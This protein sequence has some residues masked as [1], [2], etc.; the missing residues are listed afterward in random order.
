M[1]YSTRSQANDSSQRLDSPGIHADRV[2]QRTSFKAPKTEPALIETQ[3]NAPFLRLSQQEPNAVELLR[4][5]YALNGGKPSAELDSLIDEL[6]QKIPA[7]NGEGTAEIRANIIKVIENDESVTASS[8]KADVESKAEPKPKSR[9]PSVPIVKT[10]DSDGDTVSDDESVSSTESFY[11]A[12]GEEVPSTGEVPTHVFLTKDF[13]KQLNK[14]AAKSGVQKK[15]AQYKSDLESAKA[16]EPIQTKIAEATK[17]IEALVDMDSFNKALDAVKSRVDEIA[18]ATSTEKASVVSLVRQ[19]E[20]QNRREISVL[21]GNKPVAEGFATAGK[22]G[23]VKAATMWQA[24]TAFSSVVRENASGAFQKI[25][26]KINASQQKVAEPNKPEIELNMAKLNALAKRL[27]KVQEL[28]KEILSRLKAELDKAREGSDNKKTETLE[29]QVDK[30]RENT[31]EKKIKEHKDRITSLR[32]AVSAADTDVKLINNLAEK[33][34]VKTDSKS[35]AN[36]LPF[37]L[38][39]LANGAESPIVKSGFSLNNALEYLVVGKGNHAMSRS[40]ALRTCLNEFGSEFNIFDNRGNHSPVVLDGA[41]RSFL[42][43]LDGALGEPNS[44]RSEKI[45]Q[46]FGEVQIDGTKQ[47]GRVFIHKLAACNVSAAGFNPQTLQLD[48]PSL[49]FKVETGFG[50]TKKFIPGRAGVYARN[51]AEHLGNRLQVLGNISSNLQAEVFKNGAPVDLQASLITPQNAAEASSLIL[52]ALPNDLLTTN[53]EEVTTFMKLAREF[54][55][56]VD[57][58][59]Q[60]NEAFDSEK[61]DLFKVKFNEF[62]VKAASWVANRGEDGGAGKSVAAAHEISRDIANSRKGFF[63]SAPVA[64]GN[65][66]N[67]AGGRAI[68]ESVSAIRNYVSTVNQKERLRQQFV[69]PENSAIVSGLKRQLL[70]L[71]DP[72]NE[73]EANNARAL[74]TYLEGKSLSVKLEGQLSPNLKKSLLDVGN[75]L[76]RA[77]EPRSNGKPAPKVIG[78]TSIQ[79]NSIKNYASSNLAKFAADATVPVRAAASTA[80]STSAPAARPNT[81]QSSFKPS[82]VAPNLKPNAAANVKANDAKRS[83]ASNDEWI[84]NVWRNLLGSNPEG[85]MANIKGGYQRNFGFHYPEPKDDSSAEYE[86]TYSENSQTYFKNLDSLDEIVRHA[87]NKLDDIPSAVLK[88]MRDLL[89]VILEIEGGHAINAQ[90]TPLE[91]RKKD[92][93]DVSPNQFRCWLRSSWG[94]AVSTLSRDE[95]INKVDAASEVLRQD[96]LRNHKGLSRS[97]IGQIYDQIQENPFNGI[98]NN[99]ELENKQLDLMLAIVSQD[100]ALLG[101]ADVNETFQKLRQSKPAQAEQDFIISFMQALDLPVIIH[102]ESTSVP[103]IRLP[104]GFDSGKYGHPDTW[105]TIWHSGTEEEGHY[106]FY[107]KPWVIERL[108]I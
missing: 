46:F 108:E 47:C 16:G 88:Q 82:G 20:L 32:R 54:E 98:L 33:F 1:V 57:A 15:L 21:K 6:A 13:Q 59:Q 100:S 68:R 48:A 4:A 61:L 31:G 42:A 64:L 24:N 69:R 11:T 91:E 9:S 86:Q 17:A 18:K 96:P 87:G 84:V 36:R 101:R 10:V 93:Q 37:S 12:N 43:T 58:A 56:E 60:N 29:S 79:T 90:L 38:P 28:E 80:A 76:H 99:P 78:L 105:P 77:W 95:F 8:K 92:I 39:I 83:S 25:Q 72:K 66:F 23:V 49:A 50:P 7:R 34:G 97:E 63:R 94:A 2:P 52:A 81:T 3:R 104:R 40:L 103:D 107:S 53:H 102:S 89:P 30:C 67:L 74:I 85:S 45:F 27:P 22:S 41:K 55:D 62:H 65:F 51:P 5:C 14:V 19:T 106:E 35:K 26:L 70:P 75:F 73:V 44:K 71:A